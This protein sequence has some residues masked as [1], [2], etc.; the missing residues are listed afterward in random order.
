MPNSVMPRMAFITNR[1]SEKNKKKLFLNSVLDF[2][3]SLSGDR[4]TL[5]IISVIAKNFPRTAG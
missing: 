2:L 4:A 5:V 3:E 1:G